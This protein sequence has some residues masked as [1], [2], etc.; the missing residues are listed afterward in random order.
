MSQSL[1]S[2]GTDWNKQLSLPNELVTV[3]KQL[4]ILSALKYLCCH[5]SGDKYLSNENI[6]W[7]KCKLE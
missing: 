2:V 4:S 3:A 5:A 7:E 6:S 1:K